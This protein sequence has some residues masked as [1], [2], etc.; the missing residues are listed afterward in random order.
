MTKGLADSDRAYTDRNAG[1]KTKQKN[2]QLCFEQKTLRLTKN[3][4]DE[5]GVASLKM[6]K[7]G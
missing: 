3:H 6:I 4:P 2:A 7:N 1:E 5:F